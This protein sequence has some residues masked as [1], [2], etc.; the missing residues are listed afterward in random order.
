M[1]IKVFGIWL[2]AANIIQLQPNFLLRGL[3]PKYSPCAII[4]QPERGH[5]VDINYI[6][7]DKTCDEVAAEINKQIKEASK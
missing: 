7:T 5:S 2:M 3:G 4:L 1:L 6:A